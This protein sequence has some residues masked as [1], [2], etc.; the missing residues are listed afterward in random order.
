MNLKEYLFSIR[1]EPRAPAAPREPRY[2]PTKYSWMLIICVI[3]VI[4]LVLLGPIGVG[5]D[6]TNFVVALVAAVIAYVNTKWKE[7]EPKFINFTIAIVLVISAIIF[8]IINNNFTTSF[9]YG[10][11]IVI[12]AEI[13]GITI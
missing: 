5:D 7:M 2:K 3:L 9:N 8:S 12:A 6:I 4:L 11:L 10:L 13:T 1:G